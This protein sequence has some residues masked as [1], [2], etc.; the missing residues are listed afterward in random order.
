MNR[1]EIAT[2][3]TFVVPTPFQ[4]SFV[5]GSGAVSGGAQSGEAVFV[6]V[7]TKNGIV[8]WGEQRALPT[9]S[10]ETWETMLV[11]IERHLG[12]LTTGLTPFDIALFHQRADRA[13][14]P[15][16]SNGFPFARA[17]VD[18][19]MHDAAGKLAQAPVHDLLGGRIH[20]TIPL[21]SAVGVGSAEFV[22]ERV[23]QGHDYGAYKIKLRGDVD[24]DVAAINAASTASLGQPL[25][26]DANQSYQPAKLRQLLREV[27]DVPRIFCIEQPVPSTD[28]AGMHRC[29]EIIDLP[30]AIDEGAFSAEDFRRSAQLDAA[31]L[32]VVKV[33][34]AGGL[35]A[36][37]EAL[38]VAR[39]SGLDL[40]ASGLTD[41]GIAFA[42]ALHVFSG[43]DLA[44]PAELN[45]PELLADLFVEGIQIEA[46]VATVPTGPG[47]GITVDEDKVR[48]VAFSQDPLIAAARPAR[49]EHA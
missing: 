2:I 45:G 40:L 14:S 16:V 26:L 37:T 24:A 11:V 30:V 5:L 44:L 19:A 10:Y 38:N 17:A 46:A 47:L 3:D 48:E 12:P 27:E 35:R 4:H 1:D 15:S 32:A 29:K 23:R 20:E 25:W 39:A 41:C 9:W 13:L 43:T 22:S 34:K 28:E 21:C 6:K 7:T 18:I 8:G 33:C 36:A 49:G 31:D 42:A